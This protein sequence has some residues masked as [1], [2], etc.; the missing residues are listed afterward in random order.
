M[1]E[2]TMEDV[3]AEWEKREELLSPVVFEVVS[4]IRAYNSNVEK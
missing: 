4:R 1:K 3:N 2:V